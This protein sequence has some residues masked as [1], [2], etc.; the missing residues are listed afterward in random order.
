MHRNI[1]WTHCI[2]RVDILIAR[3][4]L[5]QHTYITLDHSAILKGINVARVQYLHTGTRLGARSIAG[6]ALGLVGHFV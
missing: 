3:E 5:I 1:P 6:H 2:V 4:G